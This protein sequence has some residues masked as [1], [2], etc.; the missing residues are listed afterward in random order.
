MRILITGGSGFIGRYFHDLLSRQR[1]DLTILDLIRPEWDFGSTRFVQGDVRD[2]DAVASALEGCDAV[3]H[4]AAA[5]HDFGI[6]DRTYFSVNEGSAKVLGEAMDARQIRG[7]IFYSTVA[8]Y[9][10]APEPHHEDAPT[11]PASPYGASKLAGEKVFEQWARRGEGRRCLVIRPTVTFGPRN[12]AN[13][14]SLIRQIHSRKFVQVGPGTNIKSLSYVENIVDA[15]WFLWNRPN[16]AP[17]EVFNY[18]DKPDLTSRAIADSIYQALGRTPPRFTIPLG[19]AM[20]GGLPFDL[21]IALSG[22]NLPV[23]T[24]RIKK[25]FSTQTKFE[26]DKVRAAGF[27]AK[28][29]LTEG[30][31]RMV[32]WYVKEGKDQ[33]PVWHTPPA[34][35]GGQLIATSKAG[36]A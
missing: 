16:P 12:F 26:A 9:G 17:F 18:I 14:Y 7:V 21:V 8:V 15:T 30:I 33:R 5:H 3:L 34:E 32:E 19:L 31:R 13:M 22:K 10:H 25:L 23:S 6:E 27:Q 2:P 20:L 35:V 11:N 24:A 4:L 1:L 29:P 36:G 28:I